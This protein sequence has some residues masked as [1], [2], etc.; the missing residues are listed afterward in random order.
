MD[1]EQRLQK[2]IHRGESRGDTLKRKEAEK[3]LS[4]DEL[5]RLHTK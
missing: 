3:A 4:E 1:F 5:K 2:A